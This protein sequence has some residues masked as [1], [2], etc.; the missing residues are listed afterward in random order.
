MKNC[1]NNSD[2]FTTETF[3]KTELIPDKKDY[4]EQMIDA[5]LRWV[6]GN[7]PYSLLKNIGMVDCQSEIDFFVSRLQQLE[8]EREFYIHQRKSLFNQEEQEIQKAEPSEINMVGPANIVQERIKQWQEQK[9]S[10][11][12]II[13]QQ[14][15]ELIEQ[16]YGNIKQQC[17]ERIKQAHAK[18]QTYFQIWQKEHTIDLG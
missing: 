1:S 18:Y 4:G 5:R 6:C 17:E 2:K 14:E 8:Q 7:D 15:I 13:F 9:I 16:R 12:E 3:F 11:R 10:K